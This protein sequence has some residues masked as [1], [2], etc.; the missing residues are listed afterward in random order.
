MQYVTEFN[1][2]VTIFLRFHLKPSL[3]YVFMNFRKAYICEDLLFHTI[4]MLFKRNIFMKHFSG[5]IDKLYN[6]TI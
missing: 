4:H 2:N 6:L 5:N 3:P 1:R